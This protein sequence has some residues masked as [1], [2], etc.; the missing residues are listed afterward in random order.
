MY[1]HIYY[2][3]FIVVIMLNYVYFIYVF[4]TEI[5]SRF[6]RRLVSNYLGKARGQGQDD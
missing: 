2:L 1:I 3:S 4:G 5:F 6:G